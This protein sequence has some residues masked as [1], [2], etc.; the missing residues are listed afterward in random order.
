[1]SMELALPLFVASSLGFVALFVTFERPRIRVSS[2]REVRNG[3]R[4]VEIAFNLRAGRAKVPAEVDLQLRRGAE[5]VFYITLKT[6]N[7]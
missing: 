1:M 5:L 7:F 3:F 4:L 2:H 6:G